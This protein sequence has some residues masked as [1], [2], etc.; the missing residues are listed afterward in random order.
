MAFILPNGQPKMRNTTKELRGWLSENCSTPGSRLPPERPL[1]KVL[2]VSRTEVRKS[3]SQLEADGCITRHVGRG[4]IVANK[5]TSLLT[6]NSLTA[7]INCTG[8][9]NAMIAR[10]IL[11][12]E[13]AHMAALHA[14]VNQIT[15]MQLLA[16]NI[17]KAD[18]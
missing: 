12:P 15:R 13:L 9:H 7:L 4:T 6:P 2:E 8:P 1:G 11:E 18:N 3:L 10:L 14:T 17:R 5:P 16:T